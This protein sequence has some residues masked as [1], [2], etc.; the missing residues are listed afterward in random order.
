MAFG[1]PPK[2]DYA[3]RVAAALAYIALCNLERASVLAFAGDLGARFPLVRGKRHVWRLFD[4]LAGVEAGGPTGLA[5]ACRRFAMHRPG[6]GVV[7]VV[8][9]FLDKAGYE[10]GLK[11]LRGPAYDVF[12]CQILA[13]DE[14]EPPIEGD[15]KLVDVEDADV[16]EVSLTQDLR[17]AYRRNLEA[18]CGGLRD[19]CRRHGFWYLFTTTDRPFDRLVLNYLRGIGVVR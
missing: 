18:F 15:L 8:S 17:R 7:I 14:V 13:P 4:F 12:V 3:K 16:A 9:D 6:K 19:F 11:D 2:L 1:T 10:E 5:A